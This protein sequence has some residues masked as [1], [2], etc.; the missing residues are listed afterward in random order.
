SELP[1]QPSLGLGLR[2]QH[3][4]AFRPA[5][6][7]H[8]AVISAD[9]D[10]FAG[11]VAVRELAD[12]DDRAGHQL[13]GRV[14]A[15]GRVDAPLAWPQWNTDRVEQLWLAHHRTCP[16][17]TGARASDAAGGRPRHESRAGRAARAVLALFGPHLVIRFPDPDHPA[18]ASGW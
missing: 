2:S 11:F 8:A 12:T 4:Y 6:V 9:A 10:S 7:D 13:P 18:T 17:A 16:P 15:R 3:E 5:D 14:H 1:T